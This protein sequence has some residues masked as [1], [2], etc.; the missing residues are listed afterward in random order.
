[1]KSNELG[2]TYEHRTICR[3]HQ[4][5]V[6]RASCPPSASLPNSSQLHDYHHLYIKEQRVNKFLEEENLLLKRERLKWMNLQSELG[7]V[8]DEKR[9]VELRLEQLEEEN[10]SL[11]ANLNQ[12]SKNREEGKGGEEAQG[13]RKN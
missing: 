4:E 12:L 10:R 8:T 1:M 13:N 7:Q 9:A 6:Q 3:K 2:C 5:I 11:R